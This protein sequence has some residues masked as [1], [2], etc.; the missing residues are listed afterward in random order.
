MRRAHRSRRS[1][2]SVSRQRAVET[3]ES[4][5]LMATLSVDNIAVH[6]TDGD[7]VF[8]LRLD[9]P[10][11]HAV[12]VDVATASGTT[13]A[14]D[15][16]SLSVTVPF[17]PG[18]I[19]KEI[20]VAVVDDQLH[21]ADETFRLQLFNPMG[22]DLSVEQ[23]VATILDDDA[24]GMTNRVDQF[25]LQGGDMLHAGNLVERMAIGSGVTLQYNSL[26]D[27]RPII[28]V[29]S[30]WPQDAPLPDQLEATITLAGAAS[31]AVVFDVSE[32]QPGEEVRFPFQVDASHLP[33]G[34]YDWNVRL[35]EHHG[36]AIS[37]RSFAGQTTLV[38]GHDSPFGR[39]WHMSGLDRLH[40][41]EDSV[42]LEYGHG[43]SR[44]VPRESDH[45]LISANG[46]RELPDGNFELSNGD[47]M[48]DRFDPQGLLVQR[49]DAR[50][51]ATHFTYDL[52]KRLTSIRDQWLRTTQFSYTDGYLDQVT[53]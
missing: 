23:A 10:A 18:Q 17:A 34:N 37:T 40:V 12:A 2:R 45:E 25:D 9:A 19:S 31:E 14:G 41:A 20:R 6:E 28:S 24:A 47:G 36:D 22:L 3:L 49:T 32:V 42:T 50:G 13:S 27:A 33:T 51:N 29:E 15:I 44:I 4:R 48:V 52:Q 46:L 30:V 21:E 7:A 1:R 11:D 8:E 43:G 35:V 26:R 5:H 38:N 53:G 39:H 16:D